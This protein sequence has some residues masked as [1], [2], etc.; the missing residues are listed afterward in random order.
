[1]QLPSAAVFLNDD[2]FL[3][4]VSVPCSCFCNLKRQ[5]DAKQYI[6]EPFWASGSLGHVRNDALLH[7]GPGL[8]IDISGAFCCDCTYLART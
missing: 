5:T 8:F 3:E 4:N 2:P 1:M 6:G 7:V